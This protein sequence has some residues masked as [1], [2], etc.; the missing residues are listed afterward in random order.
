MLVFNGTTGSCED[1]IF[2]EKLL[3]CPFFASPVCLWFFHL[4]PCFD[5]LRPEKI[6]FAWGLRSAY[7]SHNITSQSTV[8]FTLWQSSPYS[9]GNS[10]PIVRD[11]RGKHQSTLFCVSRW[12]VV[13]FGDLL[14]SPVFLHQILTYDK[15]LRT[16][17]L[18]HLYARR[19]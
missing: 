2:S 1:T 18:L 10:R 3:F 15:F 11:H 7:G 8:K 5:R 19:V 12:D 4:V 17:S 13:K 6:S 14:S 9:R 16:Y